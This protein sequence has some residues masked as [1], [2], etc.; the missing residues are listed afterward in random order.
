VT[1]PELDAA[2]RRNTAL[3]ATGMACLFGMTQLTAAV[4]SVTWVL[5]TGVDELLGAAPA[6]ALAS[7]AFAALPA[8]RAMDRFGRVPVLMAGFATA[9]AGCAVIA[10]GAHTMSTPVAILGFV[11]AGA[12]TGVV[13]LSRTAAGDMYP[14]ERRARGVSLV[15]SGAV[16]GAALGP[17]VFTP[18][19]A[20]R[21]LEADALVVPWLVGGGFMLA[22]MVVVSRVRPDPTVIAAS[23]GR[24][25]DAAPAAPAAP[26]SEIVRRPGAPGALLAATTCFAVMVAVMNL[27]GHVLIGHGHAQHTIFPVVAVHLLGMFGLVLVVGRLVDRVGRTA[28]MRGGLLGIAASCALLG[29]VDSVGA[30]GVALFGVGLG[31][32]FAYVAATTALSEIAGPAE[33]GKLLGLSDMVAGLSGA[34]LALGGGYTLSSAGAVALAAAAAALAFLPVLVLSARRRVRVA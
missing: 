5:V 7:A 22:G 16:V 19:F 20:G 27:T 18:L 23:M 14:P 31:W 33:R 6:L 24:L 21:E 25:V 30:T 2:V 3:L 8:G 28:A 29:A 9:A 32:S 4:A 34:A 26:L 11:L 10:A 15:I 1:P 17:A 12:G 13:N